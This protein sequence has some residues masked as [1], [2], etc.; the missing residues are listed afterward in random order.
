[1]STENGCGHNG[2]DADVSADDWENLARKA[3]SD[4]VFSQ[5][6]E[7]NGAMGKL[8]TS[9]SKGNLT[10]EHIREFRNAFYEMQRLVEDDLVPLV[11]DVE[12]YGRVAQNL[13]FSQREELLEEPW[14]SEPVDKELFEHDEEDNADA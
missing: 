5:K 4:R 1:M 13:T 11:D 2:H 6:E 8:M 3:A 14:V 7:L 12:P 10:A 9:I